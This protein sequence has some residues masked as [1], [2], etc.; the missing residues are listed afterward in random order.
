M[1]KMTLRLATNSKVGTDRLL[2]CLS[3]SKSNERVIR[4]A[5]QMAQAFNSDFI[6][7]YVKNNQFNKWEE[8][9]NN[10]ISLAH[11]LGAKVIKLQGENPA[12]QIT[13]YAKESSV[14]KIV[15]GA[16]PYKKY[17]K[18]DLHLCIK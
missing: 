9:L 5:A 7:V 1:R 16:S 18:H 13:E 4:S 2:V 12:L 10:N 11:Q 8:N 3:G 17:G 6:A 15:L 14:I